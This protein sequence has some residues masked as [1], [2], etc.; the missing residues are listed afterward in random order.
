ML[1]GMWSAPQVTAPG[2]SKGLPALSTSLP[3]NRHLPPV[4]RTRTISIPHPTPCQNFH[5]QSLSHTSVDRLAK[6]GTPPLSDTSKVS[7]RISS[8]LAN[9]LALPVQQCQT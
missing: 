7:V 4:A 6:P 9:K 8:A 1:A 2:E 5:D 3:A